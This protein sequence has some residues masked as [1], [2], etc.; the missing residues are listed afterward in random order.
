[1]ILIEVEF[2]YSVL[3]SCVQQSDSV[4]YYIFF[5]RWFSIIDYGKILRGVPCAIQLSTLNSGVGDEQEVCLP[6]GGS[7]GIPRLSGNTE[8]LPAACRSRPGGPLCARYLH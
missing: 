8:C 6:C 7:L 5:F 4:M 3:V 1:M 2:I